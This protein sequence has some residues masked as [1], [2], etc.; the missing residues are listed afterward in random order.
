M[1][2][3][4]L[5]AH[6]F[7]GAPLPKHSQAPHLS[8]PNQLKMNT[9]PNSLPPRP[10][11]QWAS[12]CIPI[13]NVAGQPPINI[14]DIFCYESFNL[15]EALILPPEIYPPQWDKRHDVES[16]IID[17]ALKND[18]TELVR[19][20]TDHSTDGKRHSYLCCKY[21]VIHRSKSKLPAPP[22]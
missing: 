14:C 19:S 11:Q 22:S 2:C 17:S 5:Q 8:L 1:P 3:L 20:Q 7:I 16:K 21:G 12:T 9:Q 13:D 10:Q 4:G 15:K 6:L 18:G